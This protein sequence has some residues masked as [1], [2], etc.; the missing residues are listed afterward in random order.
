M[1]VVQVWRSRRRTISV[2]SPFAGVAAFLERGGA[3]CAPARRS[4]AAAATT[5]AAVIQS[6]RFMG[7]SPDGGKGSTPA[8]AGLVYDGAAARGRL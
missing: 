8:E 5:P 6:L 4:S 1:V 2:S 7:P 3:P